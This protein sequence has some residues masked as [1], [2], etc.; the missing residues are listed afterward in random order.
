MYQVPTS[1][2]TVSPTGSATFDALNVATVDLV[3]PDTTKW[4]QITLDVPAGVTKVEITIN[5]QKVCHLWEI[6]TFILGECYKKCVV[7]GI[8]CYVSLTF[9]RDW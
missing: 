5:G 3:G 1:Y 4:Y 2:Y 8:E 6:A 7:L 9:L